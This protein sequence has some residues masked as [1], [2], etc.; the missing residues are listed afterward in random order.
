MVKYSYYDEFGN[1]G[2][3]PDTTNLKDHMSRLISQQ[4]NEHFDGL[5][6]NIRSKAH[7][8]F[9][10]KDWADERDKN[11][12]AIIRKADS[13]R[14]TGNTAEA[15][16]LYRTL[17]TDFAF[18]PE[19]KKAIIELA[20]L[21]TEQ[22]VYTEAI[23]NYRR[24]LLTDSDAGKRCNYMFMIG[25]IYDEYLDR[26]DMA[27]I[28]YKWVLKNAPDCE[29]N[30]DAEFMMLHLGEQMSSVDELQ[31][32]VKRQGKKVEASEA[33]TTALTVESQPAKETG[34]K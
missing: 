34:K 23:R 9:L 18:T 4:T 1:P 16:P 13:L 28:N 5:L 20:K 25:F 11:P 6:Y 21:Q 22:Q 31:A 12:A 14:D 26:P 32:E 15:E 10:T 24:V 19:G 17:S 30:D 7:V 27:E 2:T 29:L 8:R 33:D 3:A